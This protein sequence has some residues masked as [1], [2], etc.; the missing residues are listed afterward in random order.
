MNLPVLPAPYPSAVPPYGFRDS[1]RSESASATVTTGPL[2]LR[3]ELFPQCENYATMKLTCVGGHLNVR[4][5][6]CGKIAECVPCKGQWARRHSRKMMENTLTDGWRI[7]TFTLADCTSDYARG[8]HPE[9]VREARLLRLRKAWRSWRKNYYWRNYRD[10]PYV[11]KLE[12]GSRTQRPHLHLLTTAPIPTA[13]R[14]TRGLRRWQGSLTPDAAAFYVSLCNNG[15]G[16]Y[17]CESLRGGLLAGTSYLRK[18]LVG[19][20]ERVA[21]I[22]TG[23]IRRIGYSRNWSRHEPLNYWPYATPLAEDASFTPMG[24]SYEQH[25][26]HSCDCEALCQGETQQDRSWQIRQNQSYWRNLLA[27]YRIPVSLYADAAKAQKRAVAKFGP[28][29]SVA[30]A[31]KSKLLSLYEVVCRC[32]GLRPPRR[33]LESKWCEE[34]ICHSSLPLSALWPVPPLKDVK[35]HPAVLAPVPAPWF[36]PLPL[37]TSLASWGQKV[38]PQLA[39]SGFLPRIEC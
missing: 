22:T 35:P 12:L 2:E 24:F 38:R 36:A 30:L 39:M 9:T 10:C 14:L 29:S 7:V 33:L 20:P 28:G 25:T 17:N 34:N 13:G 4:R 6:P 27:P 31:G 32:A 21:T 1:E 8:S 11:W 26:D 3:E 15:F 37:V 5:I 16:A 19:K 18:Y 23:I